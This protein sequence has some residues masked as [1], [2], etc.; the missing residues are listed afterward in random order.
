MPAFM[1][2]L[3]QRVR[4]KPAQSVFTVTITSG[5]YVTVVGFIVQIFTDPVLTENSSWSTKK[6]I[7]FVVRFPEVSAI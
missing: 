7:V 6:I 4:L 3:P 5:V 1:T 2:P